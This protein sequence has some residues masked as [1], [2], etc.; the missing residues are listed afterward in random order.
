MNVITDEQG[1][2]ITDILGDGGHMFCGVHITR[3]S[4][5]QR[6]PA[7]ER[8]SSVEYRALRA[9]QFHPRSGSRDH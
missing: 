3:P 2:K 9:P 8:H 1:H 4:V 5:M 7:G 6:L